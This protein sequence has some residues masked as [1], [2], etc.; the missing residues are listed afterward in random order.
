MK[1]QLEIFTNNLQEFA[2]K[3]RKRINSDPVFRRGFMEMCLELGVDPLVSGRGFWADTVGSGS[4][5]FDL[6]VQVINVCLGLRERTGGLLDINECLNFVQRLRR[7]EDVSVDDIR[8]AVQS[9]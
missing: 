1:S 8:N 5:Y 4:F 6:A 7:S 9:M 2:Q 3:H